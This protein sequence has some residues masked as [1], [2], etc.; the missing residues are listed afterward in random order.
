MGIALASNA[1]SYK[2]ANSSLASLNLIPA[3]PMFLPMFGIKTN[4][5]LS[6]I[7]LISQG[8]ILNDIYSS[9]INTT[10]LIIMFVSSIVY[11][12]VLIILISKQYKSEKVL[13][14]L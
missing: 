1:K 4:L 14:S 9:N 5:T 12:I 13:F 11:I 6:F 3:I 10:Y 8:L 7:P 2:E